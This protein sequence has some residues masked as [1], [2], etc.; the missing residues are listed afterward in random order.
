MRQSMM[1]RARAAEPLARIRVEARE[2]A[3]Q[4][5]LVFAIPMHP[6]VAVFRC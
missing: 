4:G 1:P 3:P 2:L 5:A 6:M